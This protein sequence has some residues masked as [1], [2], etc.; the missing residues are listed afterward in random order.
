VSKKKVKRQQPPVKPVERIPAP[1]SKNKLKTQLYILVAVLSFAL[2]AQSISFDYAYDDISVIQGNKLIKE[3][4]KAIPD[5][6]SSDY[7]Y[8]FTG[9][10][11]GAIYR[12]A[13]LIMFAIEW[14]LFPDNPLP[15]HLIN[16]LL[17]TLTCV[18]LFSLLGR[19]F[20][21]NL[22]VPLICTLLYAA[23]PIHTEVVNNIKSRDE[24]LCFLFSILS[25][26]FFLRYYSTKN[27]STLLIG[28]LFFFMALLSK[29]TAIT[30]LVIIPLTLFVFRQTNPRLLIYSAVTLGVV[31]LAYLGLR[32]M[33]S[34]NRP[35][36]DGIG[37][38]DNFLINA[39][40][41]AEILASAI[42]ILLKY[43]LLLIFPHPLSNDYS[44]AQIE[45]KTF[46]DPL[47]I[48]SLVFF[49]AATIFSII[50][51]R[52][53]NIYA[54]AILFFLVT[55]F[56]V[57]NIPFLFGASMAERFLYMPSLGFCILV[58]LLLVK[59]FKTVNTTT[60]INSLSVFFN[61]H[62]PLLLLV[63]VVVIAYSIKTFS[64]SSDWRNNLTLFSAASKVSPKSAR[65]HYGYGG[66]LFNSALSNEGSATEIAQKYDQSKKEY[67]TALSIYPE[68]AKAYIGLGLFYKNKSDHKNSAFYF[69]RA[70][71]YTGQP[72]AYIYKELGYAYLKN[73][74]FER[75]VAL[76][77]SSI[78]L[79]P[80]NASLFNFKGSALFG[81]Q[82]YNEALPVF[83]KASELNPN[84]VDILKNIGRC[85]FYLSQFDK[86]AA[87]FKK[88]ID[89]EPNNSE[90][91]QFLG[92]TYQRMGDTEKANQF[93][94]QY[95]KMKT[96]QK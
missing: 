12:P 29:E 40:S 85:Y 78:M 52:K 8:G 44:Y 26:I 45:I 87:Y 80:E 57:S 17:F 50:M 91:Y 71:A 63:A 92:I 51:I 48:L 79:D 21:N 10:K 84:G 46:S 39:G 69:E 58:T 73:G 13:S 33:I 23:H 83:I 4:A 55:I 36:T 38:M 53:K 54:Y 64:R 88:C 66:A 56:P 65:A 49:A 90:N 11:Q 95:E 30:F 35:L 94:G 15:S 9:N 77:D 14:T 27:I 37:L 76:L 75:S 61:K 19:L 25:L 20:Q 68:Y 32:Q 7:W 93:L 18:L 2:Y 82:K 22:I 60:P 59:L 86:A 96:P 1:G 6:M 47:V 28:A 74:Q 89:L 5:L 42:Y 16:V 72:T 31:T 41:Y 43:V 34:N 81:L 67:E 3:G 24:I 62:R 70:K